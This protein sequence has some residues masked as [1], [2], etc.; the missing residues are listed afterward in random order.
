MYESARCQAAHERMQEL[1]SS[2]ATVAKVVKPVVQ[3]IADQSINELLSNPDIYKQVPEYDEVQSFL[4]ARLAET[5]ST[6]D[7]ERQ[8]ET[9]MLHHLYAG[10]QEITHGE[11]H[12]SVLFFHGLVQ[13]CFR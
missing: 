11:Y 8:V 13:T 10:Q 9:N 5:K 3:E 7:M 2:F 1:K 4:K 6:I 12:V